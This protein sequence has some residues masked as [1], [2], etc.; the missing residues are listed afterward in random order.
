MTDFL[1]QI[2]ADLEEAAQRRTGRRRRFRLVRAGFAACVVAAAVAAWMLLPGSSLTGEDRQAA[3]ER[4]S[5]DR[6][7]VPAPA[8]TTAPASC[9]IGAEPEYFVPGDGPSA[10][11]GCARLPVSGQLVEFSA[12]VARIDGA[13]HLCINP[14][15]GSGIFIPGLCKLEPPVTQF[16]VRDARQPRQGVKGYGYV[17]WGTAGSARSVDLRF[18]GGLAHAALLVV[19]PEVARRYGEAHFALFVAELPLSAAC[20]SSTVEAEGATARI[21]P[22]PEV[23]EAAG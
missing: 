23:C 12:N 19:P 2:G 13:Q 6:Q 15:Y 17:V 5:T 11:L 10:V 7:Q 8:L 3:N 1:Q 4:Q 20:G 16:S 21:E 18:D 9:E 14:A 22:K